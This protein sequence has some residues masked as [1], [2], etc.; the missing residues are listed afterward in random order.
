MKRMPSK[1]MKKPSRLTRAML[2]T[3]RDMRDSRLLT[4]P[5]YAKIIVRHLGAASIQDAP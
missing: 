5:V 2:E 3:A 1:A 4:E